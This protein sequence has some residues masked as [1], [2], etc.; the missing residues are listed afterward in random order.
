[1]ISSADFLSDFGNVLKININNPTVKDE[2]LIAMSEN[3]KVEDQYKTD[4]KAFVEARKQVYGKY[5]D[6]SDDDI[7][8]L[9]EAGVMPWDE[10][11]EVT[12]PKTMHI[13][14]LTT[15]FVPHRN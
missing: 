1:M 11:A 2:I 15:N 9:L 6:L 5:W 10:D 12:T 13:P 8:L 7:T 14:D 3:I 4:K